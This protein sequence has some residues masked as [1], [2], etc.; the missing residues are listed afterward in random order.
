MTNLPR[1]TQVH[2]GMRKG[3]VGAR[4]E[5]KNHVTNAVNQDIPIPI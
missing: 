1:T 2:M 5:W 3:P 4:R